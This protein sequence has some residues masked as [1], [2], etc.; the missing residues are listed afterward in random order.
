MKKMTRRIMTWMLVFAMML[1]CA[2]VVSAA[3]TS[4]SWSD[5][6]GMHYARLVTTGTPNRFFKYPSSSTVTHYSGTTDTVSYDG[7][8]TVTVRWSFTPGSIYRSYLETCMIRLGLSDTRQAKSQETASTVYKTVSANLSSGTYTVGAYIPFISGTWTIT[9]DV[10]QAASLAVPYA[11]ST[12]GTF[13]GPS[14]TG[15]ITNDVLKKTG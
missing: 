7:G 2:L 14:S 3:S 6:D 15:T 11:D 9:D 8:D 10:G 12:S 4:V 5:S 1:A 13:T